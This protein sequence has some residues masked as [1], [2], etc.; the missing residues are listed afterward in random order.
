M[1]E[2]KQLIQSS[3]R[4]QTIYRL[5]HTLQEKVL[6]VVSLLETKNTERVE[7]KKVEGV[8]DTGTTNAVVSGKKS[9]KKSTMNT[10]LVVAKEEIPS[11]EAD[12]S[13]SEDSSKNSEDRSNEIVVSK[14]G[15]SAAEVILY[16]LEAVGFL[17]LGLSLVVTYKGV[18][19]GAL[20]PALKIRSTRGIV[21]AVMAIEL[22]I[23]LI[24]HLI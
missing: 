8:N 4:T 24:L 13:V 20:T 10:T 7:Q 11:K 21:I 19:A 6:E 22:F 16:I 9:G 14:S 17:T 2:A 18:Q 1:E 5:N 12:A 23:I 15:I 3:N